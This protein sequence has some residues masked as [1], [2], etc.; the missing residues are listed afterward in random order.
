MPARPRKARRARALVLAARMATG[1]SS[2]TDF[3]TPWNS[4]PVKY[5]LVALDADY[6]PYKR[7]NTWADP[8]VDHAAECMVRAATDRELY[9]HLA[10]AGRADIRRDFSPA[11]VGKAIRRR[12]SAIRQA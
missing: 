12:L 9:R 7:G 3:M 2:N 4:L 5:K 10:E 1:W 6:G 11:A 8:D